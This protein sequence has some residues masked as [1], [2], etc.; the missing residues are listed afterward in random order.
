MPY[1]DSD[2]RSSVSMM[3]VTIG[4]VDHRSPGVL[5]GA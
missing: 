4:M 1:A 3:S 5:D 2:A